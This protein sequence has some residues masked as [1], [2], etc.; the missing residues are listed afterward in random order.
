MQAVCFSD[1][2]QSV[3]PLL[4]L[5]T[6]S[7]ERN[8][9]VI[10]ITVKT[11]KRFLGCLQRIN[12]SLD[13]P[14]NRISD[15]QKNTIT[16]GCWYHKTRHVAVNP[17]VRK[18]IGGFYVM[19]GWIK[20]HRSLSDNPLW[21]CEVF[22]RGQAWVDLLLLANHKNNFFYKRNV[23][24][25]AKRGQ[26]AWSELALSNRWGWSRSKVR[27]F[28]KDLEKEQQVKQ[29]KSTVTQI[30]TILNYDKYQEKEQKEVQQ[31]N[32]RETLTRINKN[33]IKDKGGFTPP[34][35][36]QVKQYCTRRKNNVD[37]ERWHNFYTAKN[38]MIGKNKMKDWKAAVRTWEENSVER[39][40]GK[41][42][43]T[44]C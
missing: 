14:E 11:Q 32:N 18:I 39:R 1:V 42:R 44:E 29:Q 4:S 33:E 40:V 3:L 6:A 28:I 37:V 16:E 25:E 21:T 5:K 24:V 20:L 12:Y 41:F 22:T 8:V 17:G 30:I 13:V 38:W 15:E 35:L 2:V 36:E 26:V 23:K 19:K 31:Q 10:L 43:N 9:T 34:T 27:K 7:S